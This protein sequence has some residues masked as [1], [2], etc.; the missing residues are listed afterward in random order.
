MDHGL[1]L[2]RGTCCVHSLIRD[3]HAFRRRSP[4]VAVSERALGR[5]VDRG[6]DDV[7]ELF[8]A[9]AHA[10]CLIARI[11]STS[12]AIAAMSRAAGPVLSIRLGVAPQSAASG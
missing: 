12:A 10:A 3:Q 11:L 7:W 6:S 9:H 4:A 8:S 1:G 2:R 5:A